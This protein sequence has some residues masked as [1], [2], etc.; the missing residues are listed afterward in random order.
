VENGIREFALYTRLVTS[1][2]TMSGSAQTHY[3]WSL[4]V[5]R[6]RTFLD[7]PRSL[8]AASS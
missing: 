8:L 7:P 1:G 2:P 3:R 4:E 5:A 6:K